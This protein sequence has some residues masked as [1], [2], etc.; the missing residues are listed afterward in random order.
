[1]LLWPAMTW[2][3]KQLRDLSL[4]TMHWARRAVAFLRLTVLCLPVFAA[5]GLDIAVAYAP[6]TLDPA[7]ATSAASSR[8]LQLIAPGLLQ[9]QDDFS[10]APSLA[11]RW[12]QQDHQVYTFFLDQRQR[13]HDGTA[14]TAAS[15]QAYLRYLM[16]PAT[17]SPLAGQLADVRKISAPNSQTL[18]VELI[19]PNLLFLEKLQT[20]PIA[21]MSNDKSVI[22]A[23]PYQLAAQ[24]AHGNVHLQRV[25]GNGPAELNFWY[26]KDPLVR[27]MKLQAKEV[28]VV[29]NDIPIELM[30]YAT[31]QGLAVQATPSASYTYLGFN[32]HDG[33]A[34]NRLVRL[35]I[36]YAIDTALIRSTLLNGYASPAESLL[37]PE[38]PAAIAVAPPTY[39]PAR[40]EN[41]L[42]TAGYVADEEGVR[43]R[44][45]LAV[46]NNPL[47]QRLAQVLHQQLRH[48]G[49]E[50]TLE[51]SEWATFYSRIKR[52]EAQLY[53]LTWVG[54]FAPDIFTYLFHSEQWPSDG[55]NRGRFA[56]PAMDALL[57]RMAAAERQEELVGYAQDV[58]KLQASELIFLP[59]WRRHHVLIH[60]PAISGCS[61][62]VAGGYSGL[63]VCQKSP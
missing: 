43:L 42:E 37:L 26:V 20:I 4:R 2:R 13:Y 40:A 41:L 55:L 34:T 12:E 33:P 17:A 23:G 18:V 11:E 38:H 8:L 16:D 51:A 28:D 63:L 49:I 47:M 58:Q 29:H 53:I 56:N 10:F 3:P 25:S 39:D 21:K 22:G 27:L 19:A 54:Q 14:V 31:K 15:V 9:L 36:G 44:L 50:L 62:D 60:D 6:A 61:I 57:E 1:M 48:V 7:Q 45:A 32:H 24:D 52:G 5:H 30:P 46:T 59:L 35:A